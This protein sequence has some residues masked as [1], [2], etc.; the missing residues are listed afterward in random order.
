MEIDE[1]LLKNNILTQDEIDF[2]Q[3]YIVLKGDPKNPE[4]LSAIGSATTKIINDPA[5][6]KFAKDAQYIAEF[7]SRG[8]P[9][10]MQDI[11]LRSQL[12]N[13]ENC[14]TKH[15]KN[16]ILLNMMELDNN[17]EDFYLEK[18]FLDELQNMDID[19]NDPFIQDIITSLQTDD[20]TAKKFKRFI[21]QLNCI[22]LYSD[23]KE[24]IMLGIA[25]KILEAINTIDKKLLSSEIE[26]IEPWKLKIMFVYY[27]GAMGLSF[28]NSDDQDSQ[29][30]SDDFTPV[31]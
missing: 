8:T 17:M 1:I 13:D 26:D 3:Y 11:I 16:D 21:E 4:W 22:N 28:N 12:R 20:Q 30:D 7:L 25:M 24:K 27:L 2:I 10:S 5:F 19:I 9:R 6:S 18:G 31:E 29:N 14:T 15:S 23:N